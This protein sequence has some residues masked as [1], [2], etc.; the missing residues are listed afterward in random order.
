MK[1]RRCWLFPACL[2][3][4]SCSVSLDWSAVIKRGLNQ[5]WFE[6]KQIG[7]ISNQKMEIAA[8]GKWIFFSLFYFPLV[9]FQQ[10]FSA[11][12]MLYQRKNIIKGLKPLKAAS[13]TK[14]VIQWSVGSILWGKVGRVFF[15]S[16][17]NREIY[18][19]K[20]YLSI[21]QTFFSLSHSDPHLYLHR[22]ALWKPIAD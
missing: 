9:F 18:T 1:F 17:G 22:R 8:L 4:S 21:S 2:L 3:I 6:W 16:H 11:Q 5:S 13:F 7:K 14:L 15:F 20:L 10:D 12:N 19:I